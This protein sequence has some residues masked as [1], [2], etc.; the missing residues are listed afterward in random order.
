MDSRKQT[1]TVHAPSAEGLECMMN[2]LTNAFADYKDS[3]V[4]P[5]QVF[6]A[7]GDVEESN[8]EFE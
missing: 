5:E 3:G 4:A 1:I 7:L 2:F 8:E 6:Y